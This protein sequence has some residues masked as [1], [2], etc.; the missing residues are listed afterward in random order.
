LITFIASKHNEEN[1]KLGFIGFLSQ[2]SN[3]LI[4][5]SKGIPVIEKAMQ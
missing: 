3:Y 5:K 2:L 1:K 4:E